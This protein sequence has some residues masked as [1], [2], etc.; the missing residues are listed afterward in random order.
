M[1]LKLTWV[2]LLILSLSVC[3]TEAQGETKDF[4]VKNYGAIADGATDNSK[5]ILFFLFVFCVMMG[6]IKTDLNLK[7]YVSKI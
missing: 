4:N 3:V 5:V 2:C 1:G 6:S 7:C